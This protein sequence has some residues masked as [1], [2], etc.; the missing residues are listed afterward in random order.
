MPNRLS[1]RLPL[2]LLLLCLC[3]AG[4]ACSPATSH[5]IATTKAGTGEICATTDEE[6]LATIGWEQ[7][8]NESSAPVT[9][10]N[11]ELE[12]AGVEVV[13]WAIFPLEWTGGVLTGDQLPEE[14]GSR[15]IAAGEEGLVT[16]LLRI[17]A[18]APSPAVAPTLT[19]TDGNGRHGSAVLT[20]RV[21]LLPPGEVCPDPA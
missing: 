9:I 14:Q 18:D 10:D 6:G 5:A 3:V 13:E 19:Y 17:D 2:P 7:V 16:M 1:R 12:A 15:T 8:D 21:T 11:I 20:W 4:A